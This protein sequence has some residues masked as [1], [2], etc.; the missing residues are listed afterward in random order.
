MRNPVRPYFSKQSKALDL[1]Q[2]PSVLYAFDFDGTL[3]KIVRQPVQASLSAKT[4]A[5][6]TQL[7]KKAPVAVITGR[8]VADLKK[9]L[10][11]R[12]PYLIGN[13]GLEGCV[14]DRALLTKAARDCRS[15]KK[16]LIAFGLDEGVELEDKRYSLSLH[17]RLSTRKPRA[18]R[19]LK[20]AFEQLQPRPRIVGGKDVFNLVQP[21]APHKGDALLK[22]M[23]KLKV[24]AA[25]YVGDD[26]T[27]EDV[28]KLRRK[29]IVGV[30]V[31]KSSRSRAGFYIDRQSSIDLLL[32][33]LLEQTK[34][35]SRR[36][37]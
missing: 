15:W 12:V 26:Q 6:L 8:S 37:S 32:R 9:R 11:L 3:A 28:F 25:I 29:N 4:R 20:K 21:F 23:K 10:G 1:G 31:G 27:D 34:R 18:R 16:Q 22:L 24:R 30:R 5:L 19:H 36:S 33:S 35:Q 17:Y 7:S 14:A 2:S 13:H